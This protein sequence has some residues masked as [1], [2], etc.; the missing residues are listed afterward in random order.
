MLTL[1]QYLAYIFSLSVGQFEL[2]DLF[3][4]SNSLVRYLDDCSCT[5]ALSLDLSASLRR[6]RL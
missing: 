2:D 1:A 3:V 5:L 6:R 4:G